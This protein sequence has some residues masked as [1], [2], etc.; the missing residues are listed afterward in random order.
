MYKIVSGLNLV[1]VFK[2]L[3][4]HV[5]LLLF[6]LNEFSKVNATHV[7]HAD[8]SLSTNF[9]IGPNTLVGFKSIGFSV[10]YHDGRIFR[11]YDI[12]PDTVKKLE[13]KGLAQLSKEYVPYEINR[14]TIQHSINTLDDS[15][16]T[17]LHRAVLDGDSDLL[18]FLLSI[19]RFNSNLENKNGKSA[20]DIA[21]DRKNLML[22]TIFNNQAQLNGGLLYVLLNGD[23]RAAKK[24]ID[25]GANPNAYVENIAVTRDDVMH[26]P[27]LSSFCSKDNYPI[28]NFLIFQGDADVNSLDSHN[29]GP[30]RYALMGGNIDIVALLLTQGAGVNNRDFQGMTSLR[31]LVEHFKH[32]SSET[33][34]KFVLKCIPLLLRY[35]ADPNI[36]DNEKTLGRT[37]L[38]EAAAVGFYEMVHGLVS[39]YEFG[40]KTY[41]FKDLKKGMTTINFQEHLFQHGLNVNHQDS[42]GNTALMLAVINK[43]FD[44]FHKLLTSPS[45]KLDLE[46]KADESVWDLIRNNIVDDHMPRVLKGGRSLKLNRI[47]KPRELVWILM[48]NQVN[49]DYLNALIDHALTYQKEIPDWVPLNKAMYQYATL[50]LIV[51]AMV[52]GFFCLNGICTTRSSR[53]RLSD[54]AKR[55]IKK[56]RE[57]ARKK[58]ERNACENLQTSEESPTNEEV[59]NS[60]SLEVSKLEGNTSR[61]VS[62]VPQS[63]L[64]PDKLD[65]E[66]FSDEVKQKAE[67]IIRLLRIG[68][69]V[70][71]NDES[72]NLEQF[73]N[74]RSVKDFKA[75]L[76]NFLTENPNETVPNLLSFLDQYLIATDNW[77]NIR[78]TMLGCKA[79]LFNEELVHEYVQRIMKKYPEKYSSK[80]KHLQKRV[81]VKL[82]LKAPERAA[83]SINTDFAASPSGGQSQAPHDAATPS[84]LNGLNNSSPQE[85]LQ[86]TLNIISGNQ[87]HEI[88]LNKPLDSIT[89]FFRGRDDLKKYEYEFITCLHDLIHSLLH[90]R[91]SIAVSSIWLSQFIR[92]TFELEK[93]F[94]TFE[95]NVGSFLR[96]KRIRIIGSD[97][98]QKGRFFIRK[99]RDLFSDSEQQLII[100]LESDLLQK[101]KGCVD[102]M[103]KYLVDL[104]NFDHLMGCI[105]DT[106][107][108]LEMIMC[109]DDQSVTSNYKRQMTRFRNMLA[110]DVFW[111]LP[112]SELRFRL[113]SIAKRI[114]SLFYEKNSIETESNIINNLRLLL[115]H[116]EYQFNEY[117]FNDYQDLKFNPKREFS[118][119]SR[120]SQTFTEK[121]IVPDT[122]LVTDLYFYATSDNDF[123]DVAK[124]VLY[125]VFCSKG[126]KWGLNN[127]PLFPDLNIEVIKKWT[128][129]RNILFHSQMMG[130]GG[131]ATVF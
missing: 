4:K 109:V 24:F 99:F 59:V 56:A 33:F 127:E 121:K 125:E 39:T 80:S 37:P 30:L 49:D 94:N 72:F 75:Q 74:D 42:N 55:D 77:H 65:E 113:F 60:K 17:A 76:L 18:K 88:D 3:I 22:N 85:L 5:A 82:G 86:I 54:G 130:A 101:E 14:L 124:G 44:I 19:I 29:R 110:H 21:I 91:E 120:D 1:H 112:E 53:K 52:W 2:R 16:N 58:N 12:D 20:Q 63:R 68:F 34:K 98:L 115:S 100:K 46:N 41:A 79:F 95:K 87:E 43:H 7:G 6:F 57:E 92:E 126:N 47:N 78:G 122:S 71:N 45:V 118:D 40:K 89:K 93:K 73:L 97:D 25:D 131:I 123:S 128:Y 26:A 64:L 32:N 50:Y 38:M 81:K 103:T 48:Q 83:T 8:N 111:L 129:F 62:K 69:K 27:L 15:G 9:N 102:R 90:G 36:Q 35:G 106:A 66:P 84:D 116:I 105:Q 31:Y 28:V 107:G 96:S 114:M 13:I 23:E 119:I 67:A 61:E 104:S 70:T 108:F 117:Q 10:G 51:S 11:S